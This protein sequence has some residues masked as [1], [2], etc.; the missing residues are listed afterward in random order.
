[1]SYINF[2]CS[3][4]IKEIE[5]NDCI[6]SIEKTYNSYI[7]SYNYN[8]HVFNYDLADDIQIIECNEKN[9]YS[10]FDD[11]IKKYRAVI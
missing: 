5:I 10:V 7:D 11:T 1:M 6:I 8:I 3:K 2:S 9:M 4:T